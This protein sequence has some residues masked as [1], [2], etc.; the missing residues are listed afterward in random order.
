MR[1]EYECLLSKEPNNPV[2]LLALALEEPLSPAGIKNERLTKVVKI[3]PDWVWSAYARAVSL[4]EKNPQEAVAE[5][6]K[7]IEKE[8]EEVEAYELLLQ[9]Q[10]KKLGKL[11][12]AITT[13]KKMVSRPEIRSAGIKALWRLNLIKRQETADT[14][15]E[16]AAEI[17]QL[18]ASARDINTLSAIYWAYSN[19]LKDKKAAE[20]IEAKIKNIDPTWSKYR[21][22]TTSKFALTNAGLPRQIVTINRQSEIVYKIVGIG[23][24]LTP[25]EK[26]ARLEELLDLKPQPNVK[27]LIYSELLRHAEKDND[28]PAIIKY[29][30]ALQAM[31]SEGSIF[32]S[33]IALAYAEQNLNL[34]KAMTLALQ[35]E[36]ATANFEI[37]RNPINTNPDWIKESFPEKWLQDNYRWKRSIALEAL[38]WTYFQTGDYRQ[39]ESNL[40]ESSR[41]WRSE[42]NLLHLAKALEKLGR[43]EE[44]K[45]VLAEAGKFFEEKV[46]A[47]FIN[48]PG[49]DFELNTM[50][51]KKVRL[52]DLKGKVVLLNFWAA[53]CA[54]C[55]KE[56]PE[57]VKLYDKYKSQ[58][59]EI[60]AISM[61]TEAERYKVNQFVKEHKLNFPILYNENLDKLYNVEGYPTNI[62]IDSEGKVKY[63]SL[64]Y[65]D[66]IWRE[67][68]V[69]I[70]EL[71]KK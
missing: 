14:K 7:F 42:K 51:G 24:S 37:P 34:Q 28:F 30:E 44:S 55:V 52:S 18:A 54:G 48:L 15:S 5:L 41:L 8:P 10:E 57:L 2:Y 6:L 46:K 53:W 40:R 67:Y 31:D 38:G 47:K 27:F 17:S 58:G 45:E 21:G 69:V 3:A 19:L 39:A 70:N 60:L 64:G 65:F 59:F 16:L 12:D 4:Q 26:M 33:K 71:I 61:E 63:R 20:K 49:K 43:T 50:E 9:I 56:A 23:G 29:A 11:D 25:K 32:N 68:D 13:A 36:K 22:E 1:A 66:G 35:A 62:F